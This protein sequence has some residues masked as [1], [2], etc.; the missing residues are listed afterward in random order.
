MRTS[1]KKASGVESDF[2]FELTR[3]VPTRLSTMYGW[4]DLAEA[5]EAACFAAPST[6]R[7]ISGLL[8]ISRSTPKRHTNW[9]AIVISYFDVPAHIPWSRIAHVGDRLANDDVLPCVDERIA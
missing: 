6:T 2:T 1:A 5:C 3:K 9:L 7:W 8:A 4:P